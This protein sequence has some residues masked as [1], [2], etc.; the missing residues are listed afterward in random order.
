MMMMFAK[1]AQQSLLSCRQPCLQH[2]LRQRQ[3]LPPRVAVV[4]SMAALSSSPRTRTTS[5]DDLVKNAIHKMLM[6]QQQQEKNE[7]NSV[8]MEELHK[9]SY[10]VQVSNHGNKDGSPTPYNECLR[11]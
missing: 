10:Y 5:N 8:T 9:A 7:T 6:Q 3:A 4:R 2:L 11:V 1:V